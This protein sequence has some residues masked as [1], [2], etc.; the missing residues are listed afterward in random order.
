MPGSSADLRRQSTAS[1]MSASSLD[2]GQG[3]PG[4]DGHVPHML[5]KL[6]TIFCTSLLDPF[7]V[8][9]SPSCM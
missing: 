3:L 6:A 9:V 4:A 2:A 5:C 7:F 8:A 1:V